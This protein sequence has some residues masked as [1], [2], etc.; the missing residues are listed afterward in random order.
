VTWLLAGEVLHDDSL[1]SEALLRP[2]GV[3]VMT[4]GD[5]IAHAEQT[6]RDH[7]GRLDGVQLW[8]ALPDADRRGPAAFQHLDESPALES[9]GGLVHVFSGAIGGTTSP[10][11]HFSPLVGA[12]LA[13]HRRAA[14]A[15]DLDAAAEHGLLLLH[16]DVLLEDQ[17]LEPGTL[18][19]LPP[20]RTELTLSSRDGARVLLIGGPPFPER[21]V[22]WW[23][24][25]ARTP[26]E[27]RQARDDWDAH[28]R[29]GS[30]P[31]YEGPR[32]DAPELG[33]LAAPNPVS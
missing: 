20:G 33:R 11:S 18:S 30:V 28:R 22:M 8:A 21:I 4:S 26:E 19:Y 7:S 9:P 25:V 24:F 15:I 29:F 23:N 17:P 31:A 6:P 12:D 3:N 10:A 16:G 2:G 5:A 32:L 1:G 27:I 14:L 13:V